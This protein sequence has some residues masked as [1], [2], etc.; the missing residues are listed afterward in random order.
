MNSRLDRYLY[1]F[2]AIQT[3]QSEACD[4]NQ[5]LLRLIQQ[6]SQQILSPFEGAKVTTFNLWPQHS[7][8]NNL[9]RKIWRLLT[10]DSPEYPD[11][12]PS[13]IYQLNQAAEIIEPNSEFAFLLNA[14]FTNYMHYTSRFSEELSAKLVNIWSDCN[15]AVT[16]VVLAALR[17]EGKYGKSYA[18]MVYGCLPSV[19]QQQHIASLLNLIDDDNYLVIGQ[20]F[21]TLNQLSTYLNK[22]QQLYIANKLKNMIL[23]ADVNKRGAVLSAHK[24]HEFLSPSDRNEISHFIRLTLLEDKWY[25]QDINLIIKLN[26]I[27]T[28]EQLISLFPLLLSTIEKS[29]NGYHISEICSALVLINDRFDSE[30]SL[31]LEL[32]NFLLRNLNH[33]ET[34]IKQAVLTLLVGMPSIMSYMQREFVIDELIK[35]TREEEKDN[36]NIVKI[37]KIFANLAS[38]AN[39]QQ[40]NEITQYF[41]KQINTKNYY[42]G[43]NALSLLS[44]FK[45]NKGLMSAV[46]SSLACDDSGVVAAAGRVIIQNLSSFTRAQLQDAIT[47]LSD[48]ARST[49]STFS[50]PALKILMELQSMTFVLDFSEYEKYY[51]SLYDAKYMTDDLLWLITQHKFKPNYEQFTVLVA[52]LFA[53]MQTSNSQQQ[54]DVLKMVARLHDFISLDQREQVAVRLQTYVFDGLTFLHSTALKSIIPYLE[55]MSCMDRV[56]LLR[57]LLDHIIQN[58]NLD[59][60]DVYFKILNEHHK[61]VNLAYLQDSLHLPDIAVR[62]VQSYLR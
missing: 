8:L 15:L 6:Y 55:D 12:I 9:Y 48:Y 29:Q 22:Q 38:D 49:H 46:L 4:Q 52:S 33:P 53:N 27:L 25:Q 44:S 17:G 62:N 36:N 42:I 61:L 1:Y 19:M 32:A 37:L 47:I 21:D 23:C 2:A 20:G 11:R 28:I 58:K 45:L 43:P 54:I 30:S 14:Y 60:V 59:Y 39:P 50:L 51:Y 40:Y 56:N 31:Q 5:V 34:F 7:P 10:C 13:V 16:E 24:L 35:Q 41:T 3:L 18:G 26:H 57:H